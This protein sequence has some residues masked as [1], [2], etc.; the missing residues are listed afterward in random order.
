MPM[1]RT[2]FDA[3]NAAVRRQMP[4][5]F[6]FS[7]LT[8]LLLLVSSIYMMQV[9][10][11]VLASGSEDT[12][13]WLTV[14]AVAA[15]IVY[16]LLEQ[17]RRRLLARIGSWLDTELS[18]PVIAQS[19]ALRLRNG[20]GADSGLA[21]VAEVRGFI[22]SDAVLAFLDAP[23]LPGFIAVIWLIHPWLGVIA[24]V[25]AAVL[26]LFA[27]VNDRLTRGPQQRAS[28]RV[29]R[30][31]AEAGRYIDNAETVSALGMTRP[32]LSRWRRAHLAAHGDS[33]M[34]GDTTAGLFNLSRSMRLVV[35]VV[36]MGAGAYLVLRG[37]IT[38]GAM[39]A[40]SIILARALSPVERS[41]SAWRS[42]VSFRV[43]KRNLKALFDGLEH[44]GQGVV[45][46]RAEGAVTVEAVSFTPPV[47]TE[48][49]LSHVSFALETGEA[50]AVVGPSG[51]GKSTLCRLLVGVWEPSDGHVRLDGADVARWDA[52]DL[53]RQ[54]GY[55]P[56]QVELFPGSVADNIA[57]MRDA[58]DEDIIA[59]ARL[60]DV[61]EMILRLPDGYDTDVGI[62]GGRLSGGQ[63]Q[64]IGLARALFGDPVLIVLDEPNTSLDTDGD[65]A[66]LDTLTLLKSQ[67][68]TIVLVTH[69]PVMMRTVDKVLVL[70]DGRVGAFGARDDVLKAVQGRRVVMRP[71][72]A[73]EPRKAEGET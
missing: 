48:P 20:A 59:A 72:R 29:R 36:I 23:W 24:L 25:G 43:G 4:S 67:G 71:A 52:D 7:F 19:I 70:R 13:I 3:V 10:D 47:G 22:G 15:I 30:A 2:L 11:R 55:L 33:V 51:A 69:H 58:P 39:I 27:V 42:Y 44:T 28:L 12:L 60:A 54:I 16:G 34:I 17:A 73:P 35:Q 41:I 61:H 8:N 14:V 21:D 26:F 18:S 45:L 63:R 62:H 32:L 64:R 5:L 53:G 40:A 9:F 31:I 38:S 49:T 65:R 1:R 57:R 6:V 68:K 50:C 56:Q 46:P 37:D 66:L